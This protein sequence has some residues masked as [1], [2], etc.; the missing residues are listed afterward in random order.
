MSAEYLSSHTKKQTYEHGYKKGQSDKARELEKQIAKLKHDALTAQQTN[1]QLNAMYHISELAHDSSLSIDSLY[2]KI[3]DVLSQLIDTTNFFIARLRRNGSCLEFVLFSDT[4]GA[5]FE[6][7][8]DFPFRPL[9]R[10]FSELVIE[11]Q[12]PVLLSSDEMRKM[13]TENE[14]D[15]RKVFPASWLGIPLKADDDILGVLVIQSYDP[16]ITYSEQDVEM[17]SFV[18]QNVSYAIKRSEERLAKN[19]AFQKAIEDSKVDNLTGLLNRSSLNVELENIF[20]KQGSTTNTI[21][22]LFIDLDGFKMV[23]DRL[24]HAVGDSVLQIVS[25]RL[26]QATRSEDK[27]FRLGGDEFVCLLTSDNVI[28]LAQLIAR[29]VIE[30]LDKPIKID[31]NEVSVGASIGIACNTTS[32][33]PKTLIEMADE[34][35]YKI[36]AR[37]KNGYNMARI[38]TA[39]PES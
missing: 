33:T 3:K 17:L 10:G 15:Y 9:K 39:K 32:S 14:R 19:L 36:K 2:L 23:N 31:D 7:E 13:C 29:R 34:A 5:C 8:S 4:K 16:T 37:G 1:A 22:L 20:N 21:A 38:D 26:R 35:M 27:L 12:K 11:Q 18:S 28:E 6:S 30:S 24:G 25:G